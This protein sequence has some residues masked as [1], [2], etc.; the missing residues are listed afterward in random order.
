MGIAAIAAALGLLAT[1]STRTKDLALL[2][3]LGASR[4]GLA[5]VAL[6]ESAMIGIGALALGLLLAAGLLAMTRDFLLVRTGLLLQPE[7]DASLI[8]LLL[9]G[10]GLAILLAAAVPSLRAMRT[11]MEELLQS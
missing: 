7:P 3:A 10:T 11:D 1:M 5:T 4:A 6:C 2:R 8:V 9:G